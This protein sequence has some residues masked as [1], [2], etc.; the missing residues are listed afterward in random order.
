MTAASY[1]V[2]GIPMEQQRAR[3]KLVVAVYAVLLMFCVGSIVF[4][5]TAPIAYNWTIYVTMA[6]AMLVFGG[7]GGVGGRYGL[8]KPFP[9]KPPRPEPVMVDAIRLQLAPMTA[10]TPDESSWKNDERELSRRDRAHYQA[11]QVVASAFP[12]VLL[13]AALGLKV[14]QGSLQLAWLTTTTVLQSI[15]AVALLE[16]VLAMTLPAAII[17]WNEPDIDLG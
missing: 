5:R 2:F 16:T 4:A 10:G 15:F 12:V 3:R 17:L 14:A 9:N 1:K 6:A 13:L 11:Y 7:V 8:I